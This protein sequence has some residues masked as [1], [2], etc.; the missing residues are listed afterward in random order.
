MRYRAS[1]VLSLSWGTVLLALSLSGCASEPPASSP[2]AEPSDSVAATPPR[3]ETPIP[4]VDSTTPSV[5]DTTPAVASHGDLTDAGLLIASCDK[6]TSMFGWGA[7]AVHLARIN[8]ET[9]EALASLTLPTSLADPTLG[10]LSS[11]L[12]CD[13]GDL[14]AFSEDFR[15]VVMH[16]AA[17]DNDRHIGIMDTHTLEFTDVTALSASSGF[18]ATTSYDDKPTIDGQT[19][20]WTRNREE[21]W[22]YDITSGEAQRTDRAPDNKPK[23]SDQVF[24]ISPDERTAAVTGCP[25]Q[26]GNNPCDSDGQYGP[27]GDLFILPV[28]A[29]DETHVQGVTIGSEQQFQYASLLGWLDDQRL[30]VSAGGTSQIYVVDVS[31]YTTGRVA[32][33]PPQLSAVGL[34]PENSRSNTN[35]TPSPDGSHIA[36]LSIGPE[37]QQEVYTVSATGDGA[38]TTLDVS[39]GLVANAQEIRLLNWN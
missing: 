22:E 16:E 5:D 19:L 39:A 3:E 12:T 35:I 20:S 6:T 10:A 11:G 14:S 24:F 4:F 29:S 28:E 32:E 13:R 33:T 37:A 23:T 34:L 21:V 26:S 15:Y 18:S 9:G 27:D 38:P 30:L 7:D 36:F 17:V 8:P 2:E 25:I 31:G 1:K